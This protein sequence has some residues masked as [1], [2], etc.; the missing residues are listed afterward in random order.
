MFPQLV[1]IIAPVFIVATTGYFWVRFGGRTDTSLITS[2]VTLIGTPCLVFSTLVNT[3]TEAG[4]FAEIA[5][6]AALALIVFLLL[7]SLILRLAKLPFHTYLP[8]LMFGNSGNL[9]L[10]LCLFAFG[11]EGLAMAI[12][13]FTVSAIG[14]FTIG[15][16]IASG[17][18]SPAKVLKTPIIYAV[19]AALL[20]MQFKVPVPL[21]LSDTT[22]L[23]GGLTI[24]LMLLAL[25]MSLASLS[26]KRLG[27]AGLLAVLRLAL[28]IAVGFT[29]AWAF[30]LE[31]AARGVIIIQCSM[32]V[33][34][35]NFLFA[36]EHGREA[37]A[38]AAMVL[39]STV[40][41]FALLPILLI[42]VL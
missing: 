42:A 30:D 24:P 3:S 19:G 36:A 29:L 4:N 33:A 8:A 39:V 31:G 12:A 37:D 38:V 5:G 17:A 18:A 34:V 1:N 15:N 7:G 21:W 9:G 11:Q 2:L 25:G 41:A 22:S 35:F 20:V 40:C 32:P 14:N 27:R 26:H 6:L 16:W 28:G 10:P 13:F 23:L